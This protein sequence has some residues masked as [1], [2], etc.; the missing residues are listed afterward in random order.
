M[1]MNPEDIPAAI[2]DDTRDALALLLACLN[3]DEGAEE[4]IAANC[5]MR[6]V[7][8]IMTSMTVGAFVES[9]GEDGARKEIKRAIRKEAMY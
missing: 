7:L 4:L 5:N 9:F 1:S 2:H 6:G 3:E 8:A